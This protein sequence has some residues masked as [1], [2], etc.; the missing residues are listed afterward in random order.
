[1]LLCSVGECR[2]KELAILL[3]DVVIIEIPPPSRFSVFQHDS[4]ACELL[5]STLV[6]IVPHKVNHNKALSHLDF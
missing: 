2:R 5:H 1:M 6:G 3:D 4:K